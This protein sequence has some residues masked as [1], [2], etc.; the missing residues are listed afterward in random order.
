MTALGA[1]LLGLN[2]FRQIYQYGDWIAQ[3]CFQHKEDFD[4]GVKLAIA[5][6][7]LISTLVIPCF[8]K[9]E[10]QSFLSSLYSTD[11]LIGHRI[12]EGGLRC[13]EIGRSVYLL[14][15]NSPA[16]DRTVHKLQ[17]FWN[18][19]NIGR[20]A[21]QIFQP[22]HPM[23]VYATLTLCGLD[24]LSK[25]AFVF[26]RFGIDLT[27]RATLQGLC[28]GLNSASAA[29]IIG[30]V[31]I[32]Q[33]TLT[34]L[35]S[36]S[37]LVFLAASIK[38]ATTV[39]FDDL[40]YPQTANRNLLERAITI[41]TGVPIGMAAMVGFGMSNSITHCISIITNNLIFSSGVFFAGASFRLAFDALKGH[42][43]TWNQLEKFGYCVLS[44]ASL[45]VEVEDIIT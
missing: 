37:L 41:L 4:T 13:V 18:I 25:A 2:A 44:L 36:T 33:H 14:Y 28:I 35:A 6:S 11:T 9:L 29:A 30:A 1:S 5:S 34:S 45:V 32:R 10:N 17:I 20:L 22:A 16:L 3:S 27:M 7:D 40:G 24:A 19:L 15:K 31:H 23:V 26:H 43:M 12:V 21:L 8:S 39:F 42:I 38:T